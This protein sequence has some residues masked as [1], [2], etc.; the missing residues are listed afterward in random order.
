MT[1]STRAEIITRRSYCRPLNDEG[2]TFESWEQ[3][4]ERVINHQ[5]WLWERA[6]T[7]TKL[8]DMPLHDITEDMSE[9]VRLDNEQ[10]WELYELGELMLERKALPSGRTLWLGGTSIAKKREA[11]MFNCSHIS[12]ETIYDFVDA[13]WLLLQGKLHSSV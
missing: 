7:S 10:E 1:V 6:L 2:T 11:S 13:F 8:P 12:L 9:W 4:V 3:V 5:R